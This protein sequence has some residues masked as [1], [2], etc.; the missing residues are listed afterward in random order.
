MRPLTHWKSLL[1]IAVTAAGISCSPRP[2]IN[3][4]QPNALD[5]SFFVGANL[6]DPS[7]DPEFYTRGSLIDVGYGASQDGLFTATYAQPISRIKWVIQ[8]TLLV[9]RLTYERV[10]GTDGKGAGPSAD[11]GVV[12]AAFKIESHFDIIRD[13]NPSTGEQQNILVENTTDRPWNERQY[14][15]VDWSQNLATDTYDFD[16][17]AQVGVGGSVTYSPLAYYINDPNSPDAPYFDTT[18]GYFDVTV[19]AFAQPQTINLAQFGFGTGSYPACDFDADFQGGSGP[20]GTCDPVELTI[21]HSF[22]RVVNTDYEPEDWIGPKFSAYGAFT[23]ER[24]GYAA[25]YGLSD[26]LWHR[27]IDRY[28]IWDRSHYYTNPKDMTGQVACYTTATTPP[29]ADPHRDTNNNGTE[30]E[31]ESVGRGSRCDEFNHRCTLPV[32]DRQ[33]KPVVWYY[34]VSGAP[35][36]VVDYYESS[37]NAAH[38]WDIALRSSVQTARYAECQRTGGTDCQNQYPVYSGQMD[39]AA[40]AVALSSEVEAC[41]AGKAYAGQDCNA[42]ADSVAATRNYS[43]GVVALAKMDEML[44][45][46]HSP[47]ESGDNAKCGGPRLPANITALMCADPNR[48]ADTATACGKALT[49]RPGDLRYHQVQ[50]IQTVQNPSP[51]GIMVDANDP[52]SGEKVA[53]SINVWSYV[54]DLWSQQVVDLG[55][56]IKGELTTADVTEGTYVHNWVAAA[57][58]ATKGSRMLTTQD[59]NRRIAGAVGLTPDA[60][61]LLQLGASAMPA[62]TQQALQSFDQ[63]LRQVQASA[64]APSTSAVQT[65]AR[66]EAALGSSMEADLVTDPMQQ[67][68]GIQTGTDP[69]TALAYASPFRGNNPDIMYSI[70]QA[71]QISLAAQ[72]ACIMRDADA[73]LAIANL[74]D[75][76]QKKFGNFNPADSQAVQLARAE[77]MREYIAR[78]GHYA[79]VA[80]EMGHSIGLRHNFVSSSDAWSY[81]PQYWQLRTDDGQTVN[82]CRQL[83]PDGNGCVG[84]R[85]L[86]PPNANEQKNLIYMFMHSTVMDYAGETTQD[87]I[88]LGAYDF[89]AARMFYG[90]VAP[91]Y[92]DPMFKLNQKGGPAVEAKQDNFGGL[93]GIAPMALGSN[94]QLTNIHYSALQQ[95]YR[96]IQNCHK[97][98]PS[99]Y[100][101]ATWNA[102][103]DGAWDPLFDGLIVQQANGN[104]T[105]CEQQ[106]VD[107][108]NWNQLSTDATGQIEKF[109]VA[110]SQMRTRV[111]Y[112]FATD[113]WADLGN[114]SVYRHDNGADPY[115][116]FDFLIT[117]QELM[118]IFDN[119]RRQRTS[120]SVRKAFTRGLERYDYKLR[121]GAKALTFVKNIFE[122]EGIDNGV[123]GE[124]LWQYAGANFYPN[125]LVAASLVFDH[126]AQEL[127]RPESGPH[128]M[129][130]NGVLRS[131]ADTNLFVTPNTA[132]T[133]PNGATGLFQQV[134]F[135]GRPLENLFATDKGNDYDVEYTLNAGSYYQKAYTP[136]MM[137]E[138]VDNFVS[139]ARNDFLDARFRAVSIADLFPDGY[140]RW[141]GNNLTNDA[142]INGAHLAAN[143]D[144]SPM[145]DPDGYPT[146][147]IGWTSWSDPDGPSAC[148][149]DATTHTCM[150]VPPNMVAIDPQVGWEQQKFLIAFTLLYIPE[151]QQQEWLN[152]L[153]IWDLGTDADPGLADHIEFHDPLGKVWEA[154]RYGQEVL[155]GKTVEKGISARMLQ[156]ANQLLNAAYVTTPSSQLDESG[157]PLWYLAQKN[158]DGTLHVKYDPNVQSISGNGAFVTGRP[159]CDSTD[160]SACTCSDNTACVQLTHYT[161]VPTY[162][163]TSLSAYGLQAP[164]MRGVYP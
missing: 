26:D 27:F 69:A 145:N 128:Y 156:Y 54:T 144:G 68:A 55:R 20:S 158:S 56:Y 114:I 154:E 146:Y 76:L 103:R 142:T 90:D 108:V 72:G 53:A 102:D 134:S 2:P 124:A 10:Q 137:A 66:R 16:T 140:R 159:G 34:V 47:V 126:F 94:G 91:V 104:Y 58:A 84:P 70:Q 30:D 23:T 149:E 62:Q 73:P 13:Y 109:G 22:K 64:T 38:E 78:R 93:L 67:L 7:D 125:N 116:I 122:N 33:T 111:P 82:Q 18:N 31:C 8:E 35:A 105:R 127:Q 74:T 24:L 138:S 161:E 136:M 4:V 101:P 96:L 112:G 80:H 139:S 110:D 131:T 1:M 12:V 123:S 79:V 132:V 107:Y 157:N 17:L 153:N 37:A 25:D 141:L 59:A 51:W 118:H 89:A 75:I 120:F 48:T 65:E 61:G 95:V 52:L 86:D 57:N 117:Q 130:V 100:Q 43:A 3:R 50:T 63:Q 85:Y 19:K 36:S 83:T 162:L 44:V 5:K 14:M 147:G 46:C 143:V 113:T 39:E 88:G 135:G 49:V 115:E 150:A 32:R 28:N 9:A 148:F 87:T 133:I 81:R 97:V 21:R 40:D 151:N 60:V 160:D 99:I 42:V 11:D 121:D 92:T 29:G 164:G 106:K 119:Y 6:A 71:Q 129:D 152:M 98:D 77:K 15:R 41:R 155:F 163:R 45:L